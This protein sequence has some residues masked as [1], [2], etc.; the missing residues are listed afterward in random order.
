MQDSNFCG[1]ALP[2]LWDAHW[3]ARALA[4]VPFADVDLP[5]D[6]RVAIEFLI[7]TIGFSL[8]LPTQQRVMGQDMPMSELAQLLCQM[9]ETPPYDLLDFDLDAAI[10]DIRASRT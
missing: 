7:E 3:I 10:N 4:K 6:F 5:S 1:L 2:E 9:V 8:Q